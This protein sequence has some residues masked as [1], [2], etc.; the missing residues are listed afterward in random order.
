VDADSVR[1]FAPG[2]R[3]WATAGD[4]ARETPLDRDRVVDFV[5][6]TSLVVVVLGHILMAVVLW[7]GSSPRVVNLLDEYRSLQ[8]ATWVLQVMPLFFAAGAI[9]N[10]K[11]W[12]SALGRGE[13][14]RVWMWGR[15]RRLMR[16]VVYYLAVWVPLVVVLEVT[17]P[18][19]ASRLAGLS[20][21]LLWFLGVYVLI[22]ALTPL[23]RRLA[24]YGLASVALMLVGVAAIDYLRFHLFEAFDLLNFVLVWM[25]AATLGLVVKDWDDGRRAWLLP[26]ALGALVV[27]VALIQ[28]GPYPL[29]MVGLPNDRI[30]NVAPPTLALAM[31]SIVIISCLGALWAPLARMCTRVGVWHATCALGGVA[32]S[33]Y[34]W[35]LTALV[36][37]TIGEHAF[38]LDRPAPHH[39]N[40]WIGT[41]I[42]LAVLLL[43][44][45]ALVSLVAPLEWLPVPWLERTRSAGPDTAW[46]TVA[47]VIGAFVCGVA[48]LVLAG[49]GMQGFPF[50]RV[51]RYAG[52]K[53][54]PG[55]G[56]GLLVLSLLAARAGGRARGTGADGRPHLHHGGEEPAPRG[57]EIQ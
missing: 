28:W 48:L 43:A 16:P 22:V 36:I 15:I 50:G 17:V 40:F 33:A 56:L 29:S 24:H 11:A 23:E 1:A 30:S 53:L 27:N 37:V 7:N 38:D 14:W 52:L 5:R 49:T 54:T 2:V 10:R 3:I 35:H 46:R 26:V 13:P 18:D 4:V 44:V 57:A 47:A 34:L 51:T 9:A 45:V 55:L 32:M 25:M 41:A 31:H 12:K 19:A 42:H 6:S 21:Q 20:T 8:I 39:A